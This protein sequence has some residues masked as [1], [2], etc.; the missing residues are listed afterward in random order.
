M[1]GVEMYYTVKTLL[2]QG[3]NISQI[4]REL[5][6]DRKTVRKIRDKVKDGKVE[7]PKFSRVSVLEAYKEEIIEYLSEGLTAVLIHQK[8]I[9]D[10]GLSVSYSCVKKY[11]RK[12]KGPDGIYVPLISPPGEE[13]QVDFGYIGYLYDSEKGKKVKSWI[14]CMVLSHSRYKYYEIVRSQ[15]VETFLRCHI[16]AFEYFGGIPRV[17]KIDNLKSGVL[18]ANFYEPVIQKEYAA[19]LEYYGSSPFAC[20]VR[21][22]QEKGKVESGIKY[23]KNNFFKSIQEKDYYKVK[24]LLRKWQDNVCNKKIHGT[25]RKIPFEQFVDKEK[26]KLQP[27]PSQRYEVYDISERIVN[28]YGHITYRYNYYSVPY[29]YIGNKVSIRSN[30]NILKIYNDKYEEIAIHNISK[31]VGEFIT[32][33]SHNPKLKSVDYE[34]KSLE[35]GTN[36][37]E[38]YNRLK[39]EK[40][41]HYHRMMQ[42]IFNLMKSYDKDTVELACKRANEFNSISY[43]SVKRI[44]ETGLYTQKDAS[45]KESVNCGGFSNDLSKYDLLVN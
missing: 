28:R 1:L 22:P 27:L 37:F 18:K 12:L 24:G 40:P 35:I 34:A 26:S 43:L 36:T 5:G 6:I 17:I 2:S 32:K 39:E 45:S 16:N 4:A 8:L 9:S 41:H 21:Y 31:S 11:V 20:K 3:K 42:G 33:E 13:A 15:D 7:T 10:H 44:C 19:M 14:F 29:N 38:F 30:G 23:V 25:T